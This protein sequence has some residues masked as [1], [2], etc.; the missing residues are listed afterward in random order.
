[1]WAHDACSVAHAIEDEVAAACHAVRAALGL[2]HEGNARI[3]RAVTK[4]A[5]Q[6]CNAIAV[7]DGDHRNHVE[8]EEKTADVDV[9]VE[10]EEEEEQ[11]TQEQQQQQHTQQCSSLS[12]QLYAEVYTEVKNSLDSSMNTSSIGPYWDVDGVSETLHVDTTKGALAVEEA[13][14]RAWGSGCAQD[15]RI[16]EEMKRRRVYIDSIVHA[17]TSAELM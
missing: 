2:N 16:E 11:K 12:S 8:E 4:V 13:V 6:A 15:Q 7:V 5:K 14:K 1:M 3:L 17:C 10:E 9:E